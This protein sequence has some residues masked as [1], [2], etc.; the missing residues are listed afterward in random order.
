MEKFIL[1]KAWEDKDSGN[2]SYVFEKCLPGDNIFRCYSFSDEMLIGHLS[3]LESEEDIG[4]LNQL[5]GGIRGITDAIFFSKGISLE[6]ES[7]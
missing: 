7:R 6:Y 5:E 4:V 1:R 3:K 2:S